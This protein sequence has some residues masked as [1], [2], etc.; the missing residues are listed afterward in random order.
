MR[1]HKQMRIYKPVSWL[2]SINAYQ[3]KSAYCYFDSSHLVNVLKY[4]FEMGVNR[5]FG[6]R[7]V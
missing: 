3:G 6:L 1:M 7:Q 4:I 2:V 5:K